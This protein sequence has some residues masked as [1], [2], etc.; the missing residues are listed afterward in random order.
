MVQESPIHSWNCLG[1]SY[2]SRH[3]EQKERSA[4]SDLANGRVGLLI[5]SSTVPL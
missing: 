2:L 3:A 4:Y 5:V 1:Q